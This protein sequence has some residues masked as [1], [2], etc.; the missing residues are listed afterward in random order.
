MRSCIFDLDGTLF[1]SMGVWADIDINFLENRGI[2]VPG[3]YTD[4]VLSMSFSEA[5]AYTIER[6]SLPDS[7]EDL[8]LQWNNMAIYAYENTVPMKPYAKEY[9]LALYEQKIPLAIATSSTPELYVP[10]LRRHGIYECF[11]VM[12]NSREV[13]CGKSRPDIFQLTA[14]KLGLSPCDCV[15][16]E[17]ILP[18]I[19]SAKS[20]GMTV[21]GVYD[22][23]SDAD[24]DKI[25]QLS[26][27]V[28][29]DFQKAPLFK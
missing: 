9:I 4:I 22:K 17:D 10:A 23:S 27:G 12:C 29:F 24:W 28:I 8:L 3:D 11:D 14:K 7:I 20:I 2:S 6:F 19:I 25:K 21:Y 5:A 13:G 18:A 16:F 15:L 1:D 26:D